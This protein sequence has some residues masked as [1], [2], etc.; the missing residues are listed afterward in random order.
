MVG[1]TNIAKTFPRR[2]EEN[3]STYVDVRN[4]DSITVGEAFSQGFRASLYE[5]LRLFVRPFSTFTIPARRRAFTNLPSSTGEANLHNLACLGVSLS[6]SLFLSLLVLFQ[7]WSFQR[8]PSSLH[9]HP[10]I[11]SRTRTS[12]FLF[13]LFRFLILVS[14]V[15]AKSREKRV[16]PLVDLEG[17]QGFAF[18]LPREYSR[19][20][21][22]PTRDFSFDDNS[23]RRKENLKFRSR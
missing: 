15:A 21:D 22:P 1:L 20:F 3:Q 18:S 7:A 14:S 6:L 8:S 16:T 13:P 12:L 9:L 11:P 17:G 2:V 23:A 5:P 4:R 10:P 19:T